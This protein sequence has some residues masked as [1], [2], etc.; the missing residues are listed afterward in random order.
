MSR[1]MT[2]CTP[3][4]IPQ[5]LYGTA[6]VCDRPPEVA[7]GHIVFFCFSALDAGGKVAMWC[8]RCL[9]EG[10]PSSG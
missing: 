6:R 1:S 9:H 10:L 4:S 3:C 5:K 8:P 2:R 7:H